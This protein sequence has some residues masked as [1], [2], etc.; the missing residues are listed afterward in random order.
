MGG[1]FTF[2][3]VVAFGHQLIIG[4]DVQHV[5]QH[6]RHCEIRPQT[7]TNKTFKLQNVCR[8]EQIKSSP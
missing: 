1:F 2:T 7:F 6:L 4:A 5:N 3:R 8:F